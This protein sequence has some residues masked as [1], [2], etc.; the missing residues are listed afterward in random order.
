MC[1]GLGRTVA[2]SILAHQPRALS[3]AE[4]S[5][6]SRNRLQHPAAYSG[7]YT[8]WTWCRRLR[9]PR[10]RAAGD[11]LQAR[12]VSHHGELAA[13]GA[14]ITLIALEASHLGG[15]EHFG[16]RE[17]A[18][19]SAHRRS[20]SRRYRRRGGALGRGLRARQPALAHRALANL[21]PQGITAQILLGHV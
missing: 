7:V 3:A 1:G 21:G 14:G 2:P 8:P 5:L 12:A 6:T 20:G 19:P 16:L 17:A 4:V 10:G 9:A 18:A 15:G 13:V 11:A